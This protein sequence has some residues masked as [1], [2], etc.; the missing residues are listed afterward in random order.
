MTAA[1]QAIGR[2]N[3]RNN[4]ACGAAAECLTVASAHDA[5]YL[6]R[7]VGCKGI[8]ARGLP[9][10]HT[11]RVLYLH[12]LHTGK[13]TGDRQWQWLA[14]TLTCIGAALHASRLASPIRVPSASV[15]PPKQSLAKGWAGPPASGALFAASRVVSTVGCLG[16]QL[17][18]KPPSL[19]PPRATSE[20][21]DGDLFLNRGCC[22][23]S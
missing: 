7:T 19:R 13:R 12:P 2:S 6:C 20:E 1:T 23:E 11:L 4:L 3:L 22:Y 15:L 17:A 18:G 21:M 9:S 8:L 10:V 5:R 16:W 14:T